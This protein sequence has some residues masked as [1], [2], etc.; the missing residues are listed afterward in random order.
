MKKTIEIYLLA[1]NRMQNYLGYDSTQ[2]HGMI[3]FSSLGPTYDCY[4]VSF[5]KSSFYVIKTCNLAKVCQQ[6]SKSMSTK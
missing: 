4:D 2:D 6:N 3:L 1:V 5:N